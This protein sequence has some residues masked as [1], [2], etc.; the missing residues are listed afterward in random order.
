[1]DILTETILREATVFEV[2]ASIQ[3]ALKNCSNRCRNSIRN[4]PN[5]K[6]EVSV[7]TS[8]C[9]IQQLSIA[10][11]ELQK[12]R[13]SGVTDQ[14]L[15]TKL[16]YMKSRLNNEMMKLQSYH[17]GLRNRQA[18]IPANMSLKPTKINYHPQKGS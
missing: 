15:N 10:I 17:R 2:V 1:M 5:Y 8:K 14:V 7:C 13:G 9:K 3:N 16:M 11:G 18:K 4:G 6:Q 12:L